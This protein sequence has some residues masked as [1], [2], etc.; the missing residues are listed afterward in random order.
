MNKLSTYIALMITPKVKKRTVNQNESFKDTKTYETNKDVCGGDI[1]LGD[2]TKSDLGEFSKYLRDMN[3]GPNSFMLH[4]PLKDFPGV[5]P[6]PSV[7]SLNT[8]MVKVAVEG[9]RTEL[10]KALNRAIEKKEITGSPTLSK[11]TYKGQDF[12]INNLPEQLVNDIINDINKGNFEDIKLEGPTSGEDKN[13]TDDLGAEKPEDAGLLGNT[14]EAS[15]DEPAGG[16]LDELNKS[17]EGLTKASSSKKQKRPSGGYFPINMEQY[18]E[19]YISQPEQT[20]NKQEV[21]ESH[22]YKVEKEPNMESKPYIQ[23]GN[24]KDNPEA[25][26][27]QDSFYAMHYFFGA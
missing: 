12:N 27:M 11:I 3:A 19:D 26:F 6:V 25:A 14:E 22:Q 21:K 4:E 13:G 16:S 23:D 8:L 17:L 1:D 15:S 10:M 9:L 2:D 18:G 7:A 5:Y 24:G 20:D